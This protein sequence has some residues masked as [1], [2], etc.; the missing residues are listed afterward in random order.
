MRNYQTWQQ[1]LGSVPLFGDL[2]GGISD[3]FG[4]AY[5]KNPLAALDGASNLLRE[6]NSL[7]EDAYVRFLDELAPEVK[8]VAQ[9]VLGPTGYAAT[10]AEYASAPLNQAATLLVAPVAGLL[11][12][13]VVLVWAI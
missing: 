8:R 13:S 1:V 12:C 4:A 6:A 9:E 10:L 5:R 7:W 11:V 3:L 2:I